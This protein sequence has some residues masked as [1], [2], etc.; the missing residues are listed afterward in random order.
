MKPQ[1]IIG[2]LVGIVVVILVATA[3]MPTIVS[4][5]N[6]LTSGASPILTGSSNQLYTLVPFFVVLG[7]VFIAIAYGVSHLKNL[8]VNTIR[9]IYNNSRKIITILN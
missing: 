6:S 1:S 5:V 9:Y 7:I 2:G 3:L 4:N 8:I